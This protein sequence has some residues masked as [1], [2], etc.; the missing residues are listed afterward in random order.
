MYPLLFDADS[1]P[2][3]DFSIWGSREGDLE[4]QNWLTMSSNSRILFRFFFCF[5]FST[6]EGV[7]IKYLRFGYK[8]RI[9]DACSSSGILEGFL[10]TGKWFFRVI[11][12][13]LVGLIHFKN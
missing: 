8:I 1:I 6:F 5:G 10:M 13:M 3:V 7:R 2:G 11:C 9:E 12:K 4:N